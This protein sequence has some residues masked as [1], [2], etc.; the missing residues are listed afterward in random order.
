[1]ELFSSTPM[2]NKIISNQRGESVHASSTGL[3]VYILL[4]PNFRMTG[5]TL[6]KNKSMETKIN[7]R[8]GLR[9]CLDHGLSVFN[10]SPPSIIVQGF[11]IECK[12]L[13]LYVPGPR[14]QW[15][16]SVC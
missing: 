16:C 4:S 6:I 2:Y 9:L 5:E 3:A 13:I 7:L 12:L 15:G 10:A 1:M 11:P 14:K 8:V